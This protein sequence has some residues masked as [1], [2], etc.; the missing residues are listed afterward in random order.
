VSLQTMA[1]RLNA[2]G[3]KAEAVVR[4]DEAVEIYR[5]L[6]QQN[7]DTFVPE[8]V[9]TLAIRGMIVAEDR[10]SDAMKFFEE[11]IRALL[12]VY[13]RHPQSLTP[14]LQTARAG[15]VETA[16]TAG[17]TPDPTILAK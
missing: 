6:V 3:R 2:L 17:L 16:R 7:P 9:R 14:L 15:Y 1:S 5:R 12:P 11:A 8:L 13:R 10:P 4:A